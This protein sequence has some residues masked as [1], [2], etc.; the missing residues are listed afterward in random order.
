[1]S[2]TGYMNELRHDSPRLWAI[3]TYTHTWANRGAVHELIIWQD[4]LHIGHTCVFAGSEIYSIAYHNIHVFRGWATGYPWSSSWSVW[5]VENFDTDGDKW[6][7][8]NRF[9]IFLLRC[10]SSNLTIDKLSDRAVRLFSENSISLARFLFW[11]VSHV[12]MQ[13]GDYSPCVGT[14]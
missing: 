9:G 4:H 6:L 13:L 7:H 1:M 10:S 2:F 14:L 5:R 3:H 8:C 11:T 12:F